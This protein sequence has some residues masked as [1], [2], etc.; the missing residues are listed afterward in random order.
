MIP[1]RLENINVELLPH[2][3]IHVVDPPSNTG[4]NSQETSTH[5]VVSARI[6]HLSLLWRKGDNDLIIRRIYWYLGISLDSGNFIAGRKIGVVWDK[7]WSSPTGSLYSERV[8]STGIANCRLSISGE[9]CGRNGNIK[10]H[11]FMRWASDSLIGV[12]CSRIDICL[13]D[14]GKHINPTQIEEALAEGYYTGFSVATAITNYDRQN[15][16][17]FT[18]NLGSRSSDRFTRIYDKDVESS[19]KIKSHRVEAELKG[20]LSEAFFAL[21]IEFPVQPDLIQRRLI[22]YIL[23]GFD[24]IQRLD[25]NIERNQRLSFWED[26]VN[27]VKVLPLKIF[28]RRAKTTIAAKKTWISHSVSKSLLMLSTVLGVERFEYFLAEVM[29]S[30][31]SRINS[32]DVLIMEDYRTSG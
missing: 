21:Y 13:D 2:P 27:L 3:V 8:S 20:A 31:K 7:T 11:R 16:G 6:D 12:R 22:G 14:Y 17:G 5:S 23:G 26:F 19:G 28:V 1:S 32:M 9:D 24:F 29:E 15:S 10:L 30:A 18:I 4:L 25:K